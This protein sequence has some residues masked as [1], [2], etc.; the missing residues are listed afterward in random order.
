MSIRLDGFAILRAVARHAELF[1]DARS[2]VD[3]AALAILTAQF[4]AKRCDLGRLRRTRKALGAGELARILKHLPDAVPKSLIDR[5][6][7]HHPKK[8]NG[9]AARARSRVMTLAS[10][11]AAPEQASRGPVKKRAASAKRKGPSR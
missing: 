11:A 2:A 7:P 8:T 5:I 4:K 1:C 3:K 9:S 6:D 10:G